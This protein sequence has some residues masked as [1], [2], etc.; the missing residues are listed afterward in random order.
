MK[1]FNTKWRK[2]EEFKPLKQDKVKVYYC[3]PTVYNYAHI[4]NLR[5]FV[6]EDLVVRTLRFLG[7]KVET[8]MNITD[9]DDKT[10]R[11]S[12]KLWEKLEDFT[13]KYTKIFLEDIKKLNI[14]PADKIVPVTSLIPEMVR[15]INTMLKRGF[16]YL[17]DDGSIYYKVSAFKQYWDFANLDLKNL[18]AWARIDNDEYEK[19]SFWDFVLWKAWKKEDGENFWE[20]EF[21]IPPT[22]SLLSKEGEPKRVVIKW[23]PG[24]HIECSACNIKHHW[25]QIDIHMWWVDLIFPH[26][27]NEIAQSE[28]CT[29]KEFSKYWLH[30]GH[31]M[32]DSKKMS[33]SLWNFYTLEDLEKKFSNIPKNILYRAVRL[34]FINWKY[35]DSIEFN[36]DKLKANINTIENID[37]LLK[38]IKRYLTSEISPFSGNPFEKGG[39]IDKKDWDFESSWKISISREFREYTNSIIRDY[40]EAL[41]DDFNFVEALKIFFEFNKFINLWIKENSFTKQE[42]LSIIDVLKTFNEVLAIINFDILKDNSQEISENILE[43]FNKRQ[44]AKK[45]KNWEEADE[46]RDKIL[47]LWYKIIDSR[48]GS[49]LEKI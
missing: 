26:H 29:R 13:K 39:N 25:P 33:K 2:L 17:S 4:G 47:K 41:E 1:L 10:I 19:D 7:Y 18:K 40:V 43:L 42:I 48:E 36:F 37:N 23:R 11:D 6:F 15:M 28:A 34:A 5:T 20:E 24:W 27:Q 49:S 38:N 3:G 12:Q 14:I 35:R 44:E 9:V 16:A 31:L 45:N 21:F 22:N 32:V 46:F 30:S 8:L